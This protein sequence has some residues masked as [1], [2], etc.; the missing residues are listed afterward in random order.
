MLVFPRR[1]CSSHEEHESGFVW[2][3]E[4]RPGAGGVPAEDGRG[5]AT[6]DVALHRL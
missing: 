2:T 5:E 4:Q 6:R 3:H 1:R